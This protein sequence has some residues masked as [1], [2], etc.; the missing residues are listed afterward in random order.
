MINF[1]AEP[2]NL[3]QLRA[4][5]KV[6]RSKMGY[7]DTLYFPVMKLLEFKMPLWFK[8]FHYEVKEV[9]YFPPDI[10]ADID[11]EE[12]VIRIREDVYYGACN[13]VGRDRMTIA[14]EISHYILLIVNG[15]KL[16]RSFTDAKP[17]AFRDPEW[18]AK[19]LAGEILCG[20]HLI[21]EMPAYLIEQNCGISRE[22]AEYIVSR[23]ERRK[24]VD[25]G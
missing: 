13:G 23:N 6:V 20:K 11:I 14:H 2:V 3:E 21:Q 22:A 18:Q 7:D 24:N 1:I 8:G 15:V 5:A 16:F 17:D 4:I 10:H 9:S 25:Y 19:A 12:K